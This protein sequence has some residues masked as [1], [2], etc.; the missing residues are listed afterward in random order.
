AMMVLLDA[1]T[2]SCNA[3]LLDNGYLTDLRT[4]LA[5]AVAAKHLAPR[6]VETAGV[7]GSGTQARYQIASLKR[8][9]D[10]RRLLVFG[11][12]PEGRAAYTKEMGEKLGIEAVA[13]ES[14]ESVVRESQVVVTTT[15][16]RAPLVKAAW[17]H[18]GL[19]ITAVGSDLPGKQ[20]L[21]AAVLDRAD[22]LVCDRK[23]QCF[24]LGELQHG[25]SAGL[26][27]EGS[28]IYELGEITS[29]QAR[30]RT[31]PDEIIVCDL[32]GT[33]VQDTAIALLSY[34]K[35]VA[36]GLGTAIA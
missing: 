29:G 5:G 17:L 10:F 21:E 32:T 23:S 33:G 24:R 28:E 9:R 7:I 2:G 3:V 13:V 20:E 18:P 30:G 34:R 36:K 16:S 6:N 14:A 4:G 26:I 15:P 11:R 12:S 19:L 35:A 27:S 25:L 22:R 8:V 1:R 31:G